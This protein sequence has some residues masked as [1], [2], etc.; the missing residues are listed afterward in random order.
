MSTAVADRFQRNLSTSDG[1][2][3]GLHLCINGAYRTAIGLYMRTYVPKSGS[4]RICYI[5]IVCKRLFWTDADC[6]RAFGSA[7]MAA[8]TPSEQNRI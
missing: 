3:V 7:T 1:E 8:V 2:Q 6:I 5:C 4:M